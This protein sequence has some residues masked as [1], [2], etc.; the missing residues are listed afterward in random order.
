MTMTE[1]LPGP[2]EGQTIYLFQTNRGLRSR[3][4]PVGSEYSVANGRPEIINYYKKET[5]EIACNTLLWVNQDN[6]IDYYEMKGN[7]G[8]GGWGFGNTGV[9]HG[10]GIN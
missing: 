1:H 5:I 6:I 10:I 4:R 7:C 8:A 2:R 9:L 3:T